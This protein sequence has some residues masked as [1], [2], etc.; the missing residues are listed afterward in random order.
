MCLLASIRGAGAQGGHERFGGARLNG[1]LMPPLVSLLGLPQP[2]SCPAGNGVPLHLEEMYSPCACLGL[3]AW[4]VW[5]REVVL[6]DLRAIS[7]QI[8][9]KY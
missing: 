3:L 8:Q 1:I 2:P 6:V 5:G 9:D 7:V 4:H